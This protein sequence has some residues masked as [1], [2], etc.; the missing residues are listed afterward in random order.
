VCA[1]RPDGSLVVTVSDSHRV[2]AIYAGLRTAEQYVREQAVELR[3]AEAEAESLR[4]ALRDIEEV[5]RTRDSDSHALLSTQA[6]ARRSLAAADATQ[7]RN[8]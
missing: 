8:G 2:A 3:K 4:Q 7:E 6:I 1:V 5:F